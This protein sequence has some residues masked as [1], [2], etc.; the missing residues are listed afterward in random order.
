MINKYP[1][2]STKTKA[3]WC[4]SHFTGTERERKSYNSLICFNHKL[5]I[6]WRLTLK[7]MLSS[8]RKASAYWSYHTPNGLGKKAIPY[9]AQMLQLWGW[10][11]PRL[12]RWG[13][14]GTVWHCLIDAHLERDKHDRLTIIW[15]CIRTVLENLLL[16]VVVN[17]KQLKERSI[18]SLYFYSRAKSCWS[19]CSQQALRESQETEPR[20][21]STHLFYSL[22]LPLTGTQSDYL[23]DRWVFLDI[24]GRTVETR[25]QT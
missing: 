2:T 11:L 1:H 13:W 9:S 14:W 10:G 18:L 5:T 8:W 12:C 23:P 7:F 22:E 24:L 25:A 15:G 3:V 20:T 21:K 6:L 4:T 17:L 16:V 19:P